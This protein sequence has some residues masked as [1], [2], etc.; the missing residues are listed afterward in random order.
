[1]LLL[2]VRIAFNLFIA[3]FYILSI[4]YKNEDLYSLQLINL[5]LLTV[6]I[7]FNLFITLF[8]IL[9]IFLQKLRSLF[10]TTYKYF[11]IDCT[12]CI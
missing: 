6:H 3:L 1:M 9:S 2:I 5:M 8:C 12:Y 4:F 7:A 11:V 10:S